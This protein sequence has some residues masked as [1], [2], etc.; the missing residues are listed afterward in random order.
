M[1]GVE[2]CYGGLGEEEERVAVGVYRGV[3]W[4][5]Q[6]CQ[7][8]AGGPGD[9]LLPQGEQANTALWFNRG[10]GPKIQGLKS[11]LFSTVRIDRLCQ[12]ESM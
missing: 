12:Q 10:V 9:T 5:L 11:G 1:P 7:G 6:G 4:V 8:G 3:L 2:V